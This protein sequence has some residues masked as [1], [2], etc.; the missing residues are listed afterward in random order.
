MIWGLPLARL[1]ILCWGTFKSPGLPSRSR[2]HLNRLV[3]LWTYLDVELTAAPPRE[4]RGTVVAE[5]PERRDRH[6]LSQALLSVRK[7]TG[8]QRRTLMQAFRC[9]PGIRSSF[10]AAAFTG[11][12][13]TLHMA[14]REMRV[15]RCRSLATLEQA[16]AMYRGP[17]LDA[18]KWR[19]VHLVEWLLLL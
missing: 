4:S 18:F 16:Y 12:T 3:A 10:A 13:E 17:F 2:L 5:Y 11:W 14:H 9:A 15:R 1:S 7:G 19:I 8:V 6:T